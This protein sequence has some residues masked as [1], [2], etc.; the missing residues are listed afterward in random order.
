IAAIP[1][2]ASYNVL[3]NDIRVQGYLVFIEYFTAPMPLVQ[4]TA[5]KQKINYFILQTMERLEIRIA[6]ERK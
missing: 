3:F 1:E 6:E 2:I 4:F 5:I